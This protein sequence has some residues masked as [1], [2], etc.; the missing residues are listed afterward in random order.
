MHPAHLAA[1]HQ[2]LNTTPVNVSTLSICALTRNVDRLISYILQRLRVR[3]RVCRKLQRNGSRE[4]AGTDRVG[5]ATESQSEFEYE[6]SES[7]VSRVLCNCFGFK[8][9]TALR[10][11]PLG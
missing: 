10:V 6:A 9:N 7:S 1:T 5:S 4:T 8:R 2:G 3:E 11:R